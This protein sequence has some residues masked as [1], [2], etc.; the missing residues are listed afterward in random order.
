MQLSFTTNLE[1][2]RLPLKIRNKE[3]AWI[4]FKNKKKFL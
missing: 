4:Q 2:S 3:N 1:Y